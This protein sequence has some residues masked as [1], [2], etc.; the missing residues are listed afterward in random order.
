MEREYNLHGVM[1]LV[2]C[3]FFTS[4]SKKD[5]SDLVPSIDYP[6]NGTYGINL[7]HN[8]N[9]AFKATGANG[10]FYS[11]AANLN[12][13]AQLKI[14]INRVDTGNWLYTVGSNVNWAISSFDRALERQIFQ[15]VNAGK[16]CDL[17]IRF[18]GGGTFTI[19]Y[20]E[21]GSNSITRTKTIEVSN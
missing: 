6:V 18:Y 4:C 3:I 12:D 7:L 1:I 21:Y 11:L 19:D 13:R 9:N 8:S 2:I 17:E 10:P 5:E 14:I 20:Y 16:R 15:E